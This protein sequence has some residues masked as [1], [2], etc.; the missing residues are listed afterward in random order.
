MVIFGA[1]WFLIIYC[2]ALF[3][4][5]YFCGEL[6][7][8]IRSAYPTLAKLRFNKEIEATTNIRI[9]RTLEFINSENSGFRCASLF[10]VRKRLVVEVGHKRI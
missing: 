10:L 6:H 1:F 8:R 5:F 3:F 7:V 2:P 9:G 4:T